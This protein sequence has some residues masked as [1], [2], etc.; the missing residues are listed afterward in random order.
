M[1]GAGPGAIRLNL[2]L[3]LSTAPSPILL[4]NERA[5]TAIEGANTL[6]SAAVAPLWS[7]SLPSGESHADSHVR[8]APRHIASLIPAPGE[9]SKMS[10]WINSKARAPA[11]LS[12]CSA[13]F[14][15][16]MPNFGSR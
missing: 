13:G 1:P 9:H 8:Y 4:P 15:L 16:Q 14:A 2:S 10:S 11:H 7:A 6:C 12:N 5:A 3:L